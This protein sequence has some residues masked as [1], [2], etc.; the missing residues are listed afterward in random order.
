MKLVDFWGFDS[1]Q[2]AKLN[3]SVYCLWKSFERIKVF[4][5]VIFLWK[6]HGCSPG[7]KFETSLMF[8]LYTTC[9][10]ESIGKLLVKIG[11]KITVKIFSMLVGFKVKIVCKKHLV[12]TDQFIGVQNTCESSL[13]WYWQTFTVIWTGF[14]CERVNQPGGLLFWMNRRIRASAVAILT[15]PVGMPAIT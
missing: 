12:I 2:P 14:W 6:F 13:H 9:Q 1:F 15:S 5:G 8:P 10:A 7:M 3:W 4:V 11:C